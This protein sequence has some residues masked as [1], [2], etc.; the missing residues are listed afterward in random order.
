MKKDYEI[1]MNDKVLVLD[2]AMAID[3]ED[4]NPLTSNQPMFSS[5]VWR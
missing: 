1:I 5:S 4:E 2:A 3:V